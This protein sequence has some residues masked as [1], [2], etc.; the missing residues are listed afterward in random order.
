VCPRRGD[1][2]T[3]HIAA[4]RD[5]IH[6]LAAAAG[7]DCYALHTVLSYLAIKGLFQES[8][9]GRFSLN[10]AAQRLLDPSQRLGLDLQGI[11]GRFAYAWGTLLSYVRTG[12]P[13]YH[14]PNRIETGR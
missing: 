4:A 5:E 12:A 11:G 1:L 3:E 6:D 2:Q 9:A 8:V 13:G 7:C 14:A 10:E